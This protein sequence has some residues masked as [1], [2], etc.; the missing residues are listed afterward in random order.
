L[1]DSFSAAAV[2]RA[3]TV[4]YS[5]TLLSIFTHIQLSLL[6]RYKYVQSI[7]QLERD[8]REREEMEFNT[9]FASLFSTF[10]AADRDVEALLSGN[11]QWLEG[12]IWRDGVSEETERRFLTLSW[13]I[14]NVGWRDV[15]ERVRRG[16]E[17]VFEGF[18]HIFPLISGR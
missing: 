4:L 5:A 17:E 2:T 6:G 11:G 18:V 13:W 16:V 15:G 7:I 14:L 10:P 12:D 8:E 3:L 1:F 9:S